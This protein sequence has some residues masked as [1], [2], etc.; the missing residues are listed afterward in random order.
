VKYFINPQ[1]KTA[2]T[3]LINYT[4]TGSRFLARLRKANGT[5]CTWI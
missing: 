2:P 3:K 4:R 5:K 1:A